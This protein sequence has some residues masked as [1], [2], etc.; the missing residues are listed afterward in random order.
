[1]MGEGELLFI[2]I[3]TI[4]LNMLKISALTN[5]KLVKIFKQI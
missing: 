1:M 4:H 2:S 5:I 3:I